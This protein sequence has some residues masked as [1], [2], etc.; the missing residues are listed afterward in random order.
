MAVTF[1]GLN[2]RPHDAQDFVV[3]GRDNTPFDV[4]GIGIVD[5]HAKTVEW[6]WERVIG[7]IFTSNGRPLMTKSGRMIMTKSK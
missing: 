3:I 2:N 1:I 4:M 6:A 7:Y 5:A